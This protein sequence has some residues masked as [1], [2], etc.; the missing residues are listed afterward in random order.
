[1]TSEILAKGFVEKYNADV[2]VVTRTPE[3]EKFNKSFPFRVVREPS[4][5]QLVREVKRADIIF[6]NNPVMRFYWAQLLAKKPWGVVFRAYLWGP[7]YEYSWLEKFKLKAKY[8][9]IRK[10]DFMISNS[11]S[12]DSFIPNETQVIYNCYREEIFK[13]YNQE[14]AHGS[15]VYLGRIAEEKGV[16]V[17]LKAVGLLKGRGVP[18]NLT[19][20]GDGEQAEDLKDLATNLG[21]AENVNFV[22]KLFEKDIV[23]VLNKNS[24]M[25]IPSLLPETFGT[26]ALEGAAAG[27]V[28]VASNVGGLPEAAGNT[29][30]KIAPGDHVDL[31]DQLERL[32]QDEQ[33]Y[34]EYRKNLTSH[35]EQFSK[36]RFI[37][38]YYNVLKQVV[39]EEK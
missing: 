32:I 24:I 18:F 19:L 27:C 26:V 5:L 9:L 28:T 16:G 7:G 10:A 39:G 36:D 8:G 12:T 1:M 34:R 14:R 20:I 13:N 33:F 21:V 6:H 3:D 15:L 29:G 4:P 31:A 11:K 38:N 2:T 37:E 35:V 25:V 30:P 23:D 22:G 17:L